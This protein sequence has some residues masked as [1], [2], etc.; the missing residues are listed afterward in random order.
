MITFMC[1]F[2]LYINVPINDD[3]KLSAFI[4]EIGKKEYKISKNDFRSYY[5]EVQKKVE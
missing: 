3:S 2:G 5:K 1:L 4:K